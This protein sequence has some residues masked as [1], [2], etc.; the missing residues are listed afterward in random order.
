MLLRH[1]T[2]DAIAL[3]KKRNKILLVKRA[4]NLYNGGKWA[5]PGGYL[6]RDENTSEGVLRELKEE[7]GYEG[8]IISLFRVNDDPDRPR[9]DTQNVDFV[10]LVEVREKTGD[11]DIESSET[12][13]FSFK[14][15]PQEKDFAF[16]H[17]ENTMLY[18]EYLKKSFSLPFFN[19]L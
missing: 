3:D 7:T 9:E 6:D 12:K 15:L 18:F 13:W 17:Y 4:P 10:Y 16:D 19:K 5:L 11:H 1:V 14:D 8:K 2:V